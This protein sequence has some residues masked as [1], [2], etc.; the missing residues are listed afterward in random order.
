MLWTQLFT[1]G[2]CLGIHSESVRIYLGF[3]FLGLKINFIQIFIISVRVQIFA[4]SGSDNE[5]KL[6]KKNINSY[7]I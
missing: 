4:G 1:S 3:G 7:I 2:G 5:F 6:L